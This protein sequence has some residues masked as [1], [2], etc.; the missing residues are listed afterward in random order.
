MAALAA[1]P[2][3]GFA[4]YWSGGDLER[5]LPL[6]PAFFLILSLSLSG[7]EPFSW[8]KSIGWMFVLCVVL[9]NAASLRREAILHSQKQSENRVN[10]LI[11]LLRHESLLIVSHNLDELMEFNRNFP[12]SP[13]NR[14]GVLNLY[15]L[16]TPGSVDIGRWR[17]SFSSRAMLS[18]RSGGDVW[19]SN[20]LFRPTPKAGWNWVEGDDSRVSWSDLGPFFSRLPYGESVGGDD[21]FILLLRSA[22]NQKSLGLFDPNESVELPA[23]NVQPQSA[24]PSRE[25]GLDHGR[26]N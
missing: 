10:A 18:W 2:V 16:L 13:I 24:R 22:E 23:A 12:F 25:A 17:E 4:C 26:S 1:L 8:A 5:Y 20:R 15:P 21:G 3:V 14:S 11:P 7:S 6:Y 9:T 19:I